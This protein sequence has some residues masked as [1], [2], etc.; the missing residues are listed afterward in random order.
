MLSSFTLR[1]F[2]GFTTAPIKTLV[3]DEASQIEIGDYIPL[4][5]SHSTI[6]KVCFI[7]DNKQLPPY[8]QEDIQDLKSIFE[9][10]HLRDCTIFLNDAPSNWM[11]HL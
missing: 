9:V 11:V 6:R 1:N 8:G 2:G 10:E 4:F 3:I 5:T 7:G